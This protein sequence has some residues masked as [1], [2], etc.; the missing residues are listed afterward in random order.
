MDLENVAIPAHVHMVQRPQEQN[1]HG[2]VY[3]I[4]VI[5]TNVSKKILDLYFFLSFVS[6]LQTEFELF[7]YYC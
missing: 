7:C 5:K 2:D 6:I 3:I 4:A 1:Q